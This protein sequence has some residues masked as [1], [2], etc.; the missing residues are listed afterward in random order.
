MKKMIVKSRVMIAI[1]LSVICCLL[2]SYP[3]QAS[4]L[5][6]TDIIENSLDSESSEIRLQYVTPEQMEQLISQCNR[7]K[8]SYYTNS[9]NNWFSDY[10][11]FTITRESNYCKVVFLNCGFPF[12]RCDVDGTITLYNMSSLVVANRTVA[13]H[14][15]VYGVA[16]VLKIYPTGGNYATGA[17]SLRL[18]DGDVGT[19]YS[20][21]F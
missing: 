10:V 2:H 19:V 21:V 16:R 15:L 14:K 17:Y 20:G 18:S 8:N 6:D 7:N 9:A 3:V 12:D 1:C 4:E 13:E 11:V 5:M